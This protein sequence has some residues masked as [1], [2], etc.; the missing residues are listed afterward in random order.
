MVTG[1]DFASV[2]HPSVQQ[3]VL[4]CQRTSVQE[5]DVNVFISGLSATLRAG[6]NLQW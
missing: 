1:E 3:A 2:T 5:E 6:E 4:V